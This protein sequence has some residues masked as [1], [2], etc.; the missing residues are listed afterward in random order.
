MKLSDLKKG[1]SGIV[2]N[3]ESKELEVL[4][5]KHGLVAGDTLLVSDIAPFGGP[6]AVEV[7][8]QKVAL[9]RR[10]AKMISMKQIANGQ[11]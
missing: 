8:G 6:I 4:L 1:N 11:I 10:D 7:R 3:F 2:L 9:R 5:L